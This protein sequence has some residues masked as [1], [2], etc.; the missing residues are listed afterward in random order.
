MTTAKDLRGRAEEA[1]QQGKAVFD[2]VQRTAQAK[3]SDAVG[4]VSSAA[5]KGVNSDV[6][7]GGRTVSVDSFVADFEALVKRYSEVA[8]ER[9]D[10][11]VSD[12]KRDERLTQLVERAETA[13]RELNAEQRLTH[14]VERAEVVY[15]ALADVLKERVV[16]P[17]MD[18]LGRSPVAPGGRASREPAAP[19]ASAPAAKAP[20]RKSPAKKAPT[21]AAQ[22]KTAP[23]KT[24]PAKTAPAKT[25]PAK[26]APAKKAATSVSNAPAKAVKATPRKSTS[27][28][29][30]S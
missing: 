2:T 22:A 4:A 27:P 30:S 24:A 21:T 15:D 8:A 28:G 14:L 23:A 7:I 10:A 16:H 26:T 5:E 17:A 25:A 1:L 18:L 11:L 12:I 3:I 29:S 6:K 19:A 9:T 13:L 20:A